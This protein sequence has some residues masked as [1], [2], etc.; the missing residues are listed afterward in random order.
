MRHKTSFLIAICILFFA[1]VGSVEAAT[2]PF[3]QKTS[4]LPQYYLPKQVRVARPWGTPVYNRD[5][6]AE[7]NL[8]YSGYHPVDLDTS[9][10]TVGYPRVDVPIIPYLLLVNQNGSP[11]RKMA[12]YVEQFV[13]DRQTV[14]SE[15]KTPEQLVYKLP[16][17]D[18]DTD[19]RRT[20]KLTNLFCNTSYEGLFVAY[21]PGVKD[22]SINYMY[23]RT[24]P[25]NFYHVN[26]PVKFRTPYQCKVKINN[27]VIKASP[28]ATSGT[29]Q[30]SF[31]LLVDAD[32]SGLLTAY[33]AYSDDKSKALN[34]DPAASSYN[35]GSAQFGSWD[36]VV[37]NGDMYP[38]TFGINQSPIGVN[39]PA[40][41]QNPEIELLSK[42]L[43]C[44]KDYYVVA[45]VEA[46]QFQPTD[47][48]AFK[49]YAYTK[50]DRGFKVDCDNG[51]T[52]KGII[53]TGNPTGQ[54]NAP[55]SMTNNQPRQVREGPLPVSIKP[56]ESKNLIGVFGIVGEGTIVVR[57][58][59]DKNNPTSGIQEDMCGVYVN[60][61]LAYGRPQ[62]AS[63]IVSTN[64]NP[65]IEKVAGYF[66]Q[67]F[68]KGGE[69]R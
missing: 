11:Y 53:S 2:R 30:V 59:E 52:V 62:R 39:W 4:F 50:V 46:A 7:F 35:V 17:I 6:T 68:S 8:D 21:A 43:T 33:F 64:Q 65:L 5:F 9:I 58:L 12:P 51:Y 26:Y 23:E 27:F 31:K 3:L 28:G 29:T 56:L 55:S 66:A 67:V 20:L 14:L 19:V 16:V 42:D 18:K 45:G 24:I 22:D 48:D 10:M 54:Q 63:C 36:G 49:E 32:Q 57:P 15:I 25:G 47:P 13:L 38:A 37:F 60:K 1:V 44:G 41:T 69:V 40:F 61:S 34:Y